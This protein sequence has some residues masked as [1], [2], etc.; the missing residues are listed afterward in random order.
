MM[1]VK[2]ICSIWFEAISNLKITMK[3][4]VL[5]LVGKVAYVERLALVLGCGVDNLAAIYLGLPLGTPYKS[6][7]L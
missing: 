7:R 3:K 6:M 5:T 4:I 1:L 2:R